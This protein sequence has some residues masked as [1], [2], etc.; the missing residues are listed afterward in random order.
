MSYKGCIST[1][2][3]IA[4]SHEARNRVYTPNHKI[5]KPGRAISQHGSGG[6]R[7]FS[8]AVRH[9]PF[10]VLDCGSQIGLLLH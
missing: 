8:P 4:M 2:M 1:E 5:D 9:E 6:F 3:I 10:D 7:R